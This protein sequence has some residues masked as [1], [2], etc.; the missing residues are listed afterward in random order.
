MESQ[1]QYR[2]LHHISFWEIAIANLALWDLEES[3]KC[4]RNLE[5]EATVCVQ[6]FDFEWIYADYM[7]FFFA[8]P[9]PVNSPHS[10]VQG[11]ILVWD[12]CVPP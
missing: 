7:R 4:W 11:D 9:P 3:L 2:N 5:R 12:G 1:K 6:G 8:Y 10:V